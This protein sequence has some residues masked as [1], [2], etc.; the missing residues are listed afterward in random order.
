MSTDEKWVLTQWGYGKILE[1]SRSKL[2]V[3]LTW[4]GV[5]YLNPSSI[6][7]SVHFSIKLF[8]AGRKTFQY[9]WGINQDFSLLFTLLQ[10]QLSLPA[11]IRLNLYFPRGKLNKV[12][13]TDTPLKLKLKSHTKFIAITKQN[14][15]W[16]A[17]KKSANIELLDDLLTVKKK[18]DTE[19][20]CESV[21]GTVSMSSGVHQ[22]EIKMDFLMDYEEEEEVYIGVAMKNINL[23]KN[24]LEIEYWGFMC[25]GCKK[26][27]QGFSE[28][29]GDN[30][31][32]GDV[33]G[34]KLEFKDNKGVLSF[35]KNGTD[36]GEAFSEVPP[37]V[38]PAIT[39]NYPKIQVSLGK[40][41]GI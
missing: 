17:S 13:V 32:T 5:G 16:D 15:T 23:N 29:Y 8:S 34:V 35:C 31:N 6:A 2:I 37:G 30:I 33:V 24:P 12:L 25:I 26:F 39:L 38:H 3:K 7:S 20:M 4:G 36:F 1:Q 27:C 22:W 41:A 11:N 14:F 10:K 19:I 18:D 40:S 9:E 21:L 28:D